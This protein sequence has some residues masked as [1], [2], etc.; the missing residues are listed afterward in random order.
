[1][2]KKKLITGIIFSSLAFIL[3][4]MA[5][6]LLVGRIVPLLTIGTTEALGL[7][8]LLPMYCIML[9]ISLIFSIVGIILLLKYKKLE[10]SHQASKVLLI[11]TTFMLLIDVGLEIILLFL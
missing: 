10:N 6:I 11:I 3:L 8:I 9:L 1:M 7:I 5:V 4:V 2:G